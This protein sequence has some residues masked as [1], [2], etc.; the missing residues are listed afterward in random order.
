MR[1]HYAQRRLWIE[2]AALAEQRLCRDITEGGIQL[3][4]LR[5]KA[6]IKRR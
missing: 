1:Q 2:E 6:M 4:L 3:W 5:L